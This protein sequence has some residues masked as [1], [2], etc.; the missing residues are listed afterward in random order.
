M[1]RL[2]IVFALLVSATALSMT[3][4]TLSLKARPLVT[5]PTQASARRTRPLVAM[6]FPL[7]TI[8][9]VDFPLDTIGTTAAVGV[10]VLLVIVLAAGRG[11]FAAGAALMLVFLGGDPDERDASGANDN[12][13]L[14]DFALSVTPSAWKKAYLGDNDVERSDGEPALLDLP[15]WQG[16]EAR[17]L[18]EPEAVACIRQMRLEPIE[19]SSLGP[20][21]TCFLSLQPSGRPAADAPPVLLIHGFDSSLLE[22]RYITD[23][24]T[25]AG[26]SVEAC[27]WWTG[28]FTDRLPFEK[29]VTEDGAKP[30]DLVREHLYAFW[31]RQLGDQ[32]VTLVGFSL[33]GAV[34]IDFAASHPECVDRL[35]LVDAGG[36]SYAQPA[37]FLTSLAAD[38]VT[39]LF[40][41]RATNGLLPYPHVW[42]KEAGWRQ[43]L[44]AYLRSGGY[45]VRVNPE[46]IKTVPQ[47]TVVFWGEEDDVLPV[48][49]AYKFERDLPNCVGVKIIP[50]AQHAPAL[51][52]PAV[53][54][55][56]IIAF[57]TSKSV[58][59]QPK[60]A[61][62]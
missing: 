40:Q 7:E 50:D 17:T 27:E 46:L 30:W 16:E 49:D 60:T 26:L 39:N 38:P 55:E 59:Q 47:P 13:A 5:R 53:V 29:A 24:L 34:A 37:P 9:T 56:E 4:P 41:W 35:V 51:E 48:E 42:S 52:N 10:G 43:S 2:L 23:A 45:Q 8:A 44:Q 18:V 3:P 62:A 28:G 61:V 14:K 31:K 22:F 6:D 12:R 32:K 19:T 21:D 11:S 25:Q 15:A 58:T 54:A 57:A 20:V 36:E 33:G 1:S